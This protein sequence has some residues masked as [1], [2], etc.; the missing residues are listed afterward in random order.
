MG[1]VHISDIVPKLDL[2]DTPT[3]ISNDEI[4]R[5]TSTLENASSQDLVVYNLKE[6]DEKARSI[7]LER[8]LKSRCNNFILPCDF[9][10]P[11]P[12][13]KIVSKSFF[14]GKHYQEIC[15]LIF[16]K[17]S[18]GIPKIVAIT[19]TNGKS[20]TVFFLNQ[21]A[22]L[23][24][25]KSASLGTIGLYIGTAKIRDSLLTTPD[26]FELR[27]TL[28]GLAVQGIEYLFLEAS[29][30]ALEQGRFLDLTFQSA[31]WTNLTHDHLD[32]HGNFSNYFNAKLKILRSISAYG[33]LVISPDSSS[34]YQQ[35]LNAVPSDADR[36]L[37]A[38]VLNVKRQLPSFLRVEFN[39]HNLSLAI[40]VLDTLGIH[41][42]SEQL[43]NLRPPP[44][45]FSV[46]HMEGAGD[47]IV[48]YAHTP[49]GL[50][51]I[52]SETRKIYP[53]KKLT[54][55]FGC[56]GNR[57]KT[58]RPLMG[59]IADTYCDEIIVTNDNPRFEEPISI[60]NDIVSGIK[61]CKPAIILDRQR[62]ICDIVDSMKLSDIIVIAGKGHES[63]Q[64]IKG[65]RYHFN[66]SELLE[67][68]A[69]MKIIKQLP[70]FLHSFGPTLFRLNSDISTDSRLISPHQVFV[71]LV[72][73]K[74]DGA[75]YLEACFARGVR[76][77]VLNGNKRNES[78]A[79]NLFAKDANLQFIFVTDTN[80]FLGELARQYLQRLRKTRKIVVIGIT[81]SNGKTTTKDMLYHLLNAALPGKVHKTQGNLN[82]HIGLPLTI[83]SS[84]PDHEIVILEMGTNHPGEIDYLCNIAMP[85][86][87][88]LTSVGD[89]HLE[90]FGDRAGVFKEKRLLHEYVMK[91][92]QAL[93]VTNGDDSLL[94]TLPLSK[95]TYFVGI[96]NGNIKINHTFYNQL[97]L[98]DSGEQY[99]LENDYLIGIHNFVNLAMAFTLALKL[100]P[101]KKTL[102]VNSIKTFRPHNNRSEVRIE[103]GHFIFL[104]AYNANPSSME[105]S[106]NSFVEYV[107]MKGH[108]LSDCLFIIGDMNELGEH[109]REGHERIGRLLRSHGIANI[110]FIGKY[111]DYYLKGLGGK[112]L[113]QFRNADDCKN[114]MAAFL[115][116]KACIF[117]KGSR[118]IK[119]E[120]L[121]SNSK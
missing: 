47:V 54:I 33:R 81:G 5:I 93:F 69:G 52:L 34:L 37:L 6:N 83:L 89:S 29:S 102:L 4:T 2:N 68:I 78:L 99:I 44:G 14:E 48:D 63:Y 53:N 84:R 22:N 116:N 80:I 12:V 76:S 107:M 121:F 94:S 46:H 49:D 1:K 51:K 108:Q 61:N 67:S 97:M 79:K 66:D 62:A 3:I 42:E 21:L 101:D 57:D 26:Y 60:A 50:E 120:T 39:Y 59:Q 24:G 98:N 30:H 13:N 7:F 104:D 15:D 115:Q 85:D 9:N 23:S 55:I 91:S 103:D 27:E 58:K 74:F 40:S 16:G 56:G 65:V 109:A 92:S 113:G 117:V 20:S 90:F 100:W 112:C 75:D 31:G 36:V 106:L 64:E 8:F 86:A 88:I 118:S 28:H 70:S 71:A 19:G 111:S 105:T 17:R 95:S 41:I 10:F 43:D 96:N 119:L 32:Y 72:G 73:D 114:K 11:R 18:E 45:R 35:I 77:F 38:K 82:N 25:I 87:G 110:I